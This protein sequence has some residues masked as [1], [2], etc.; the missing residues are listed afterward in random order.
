MSF[1]EMFQRYFI[2]IVIA[3]VFF[4][5]QLS[6]FMLRSSLNRDPLLVNEQG[7]IIQNRFPLFT[8]KCPA[9]WTESS[10]G[11]CKLPEKPNVNGPPKCDAT[12]L[13]EN[14]KGSY[15]MSDENYSKVNFSEMSW[16][17][18]CKWSN[19]CGVY[20]ESVSDRP[21]ISNSFVGMKENSV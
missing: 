3:V 10:D 17:E 2:A 11:S 7:E 8:S 6:V 20:W 4:I 15:D 9:Y 5:F 14:A 13:F 16:P 21:C 19:L 1:E 12:S 18:R